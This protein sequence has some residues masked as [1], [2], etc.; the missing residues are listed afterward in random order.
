MK[1]I[2][3]QL[4]A[5]LN[6][7]LKRTANKKDQFKTTFMKSMIRRVVEDYEGMDVDIDINSKVVQTRVKNVPDDLND[8]LNALCNKMSVSPSQLLRVEL[9]RAQSK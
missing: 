9:F 8:R 2:D 4:N 3:I 1:T 7:K 5:P 6:D